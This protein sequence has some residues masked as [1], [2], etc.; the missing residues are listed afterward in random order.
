MQTISLEQA[1]RY[2][3]KRTGYS[4][5]E[6]LKVAENLNQDLQTELLLEI[7]NNVD[8]NELAEN[9]NIV[10]EFVDLYSVVSEESV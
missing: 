6:V 3:E 7:A 8:P 1:C 10:E 9:P 4:S 2:F 5:F